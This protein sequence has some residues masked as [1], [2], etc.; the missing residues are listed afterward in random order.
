M[1]VQQMSQMIYPPHMVP[2]PYMMPVPQPQPLHP[3]S[4]FY[5]QGSVSSLQDSRP[6]SGEPMNIEPEVQ[7]NEISINTPAWDNRLDS[8]ER[9]Y[10]NPWTSIS[11]PMNRFM[12][13]DEREWEE[14][15]NKK[16]Q[17]AKD[18]MQQ[19]E[20]VKR[21]KAEQERIKLEEEARIE[22]KLKRDLIELS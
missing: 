6:Q 18:L 16:Q 19:M 22:K 10:K 5:R 12:D 20:E 14:K 1:P 2:Y 4:Q 7:V 11:R 3:P 8:S 9:R 21:K 15:E 17:W 13:I